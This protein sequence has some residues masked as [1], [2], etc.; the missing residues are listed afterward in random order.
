VS[1]AFEDEEEEETEEILD[2]Y[3]DYETEDHENTQEEGY[4]DEAQQSKSTP[5]QSA[6]SGKKSPSKSVFIKTPV[7]NQNNGKV[8]SAAN[9]ARDLKL[10]V[11]D[12]SIPNK[13]I[14]PG[15][16]KIK[17]IVPTTIMMSPN[18]LTNNRV[19]RKLDMTESSETIIL[20]HENDSYTNVDDDGYHTPNKRIMLE[21]DEQ[22]MPSITREITGKKSISNQAPT[23]NNAS[24]VPSI[25]S[26][27]G[28]RRRRPKTENKQPAVKFDDIKVQDSYV[29]SSEPDE[30]EE[31][32]IEVTRSL[33][34]ETKV[35]DSYD[36]KNHFNN[37]FKSIAISRKIKDGNSFTFHTPYRSGPLLARAINSLCGI[38]CRC[39][40]RTVKNVQIQRG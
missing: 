4:E 12:A 17:R 21:C 20:D 36:S 6:K 9:V 13:A 10:R 8:L 31:R 35:I 32:G 38:E 22:L 33:K 30:L 26:D 2:G 1:Q 14:P 34:V 24:A 37:E 7:V 29:M 40:K 39:C 15:A 25:T 16:P 5:F 3:S 28:S 11:K 18:V 27:D 23:T 19:K